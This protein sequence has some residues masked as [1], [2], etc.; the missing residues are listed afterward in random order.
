[1]RADRLLSILLLLQTRGRMT[2]HEL[3]QQL[4]VSERTIY[5]DMEALSIAGIP[6]YAERGPGGG[7]TLVDG[8][9]TRLNGLTETEVRALFLLQCAS[10]LVDLGLSDALNGALLKLSASLPASQRDDVEQV[11]QRIHLDNGTATNTELLCHLHTIQEAIWQEHQLLLSYREGSHLA[12]E[13][14]V[15][16]YGLI[17]KVNAWHLVG[18]VNGEYNVFQVS[19]IARVQLTTEKF[20][21]SANFDLPRFWSNYCEQLKMN[22]ACLQVQKMRFRQLPQQCQ[23]KKTVSF[24]HHHSQQRQSQ[25]KKT[26]SPA[27]SLQ[28]R[29]RSQE[30]KA[31]LNSAPASLPVRHK[32]KNGLLSIPVS[33]HPLKKIKFPRFLPLYALLHCA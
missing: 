6:V 1:M 22:E 14:R 30:K 26:N 13:Q 7:C 27:R 32:E 4:E 11:R 24:V 21:R 20:S 2:A 31:I 17:S 16:P 12:C 25:T 28:R 33:Q 9:Q 19:S 10:P 29:Y 23:S 8:Y 5:R 15:A 18:V 3:A